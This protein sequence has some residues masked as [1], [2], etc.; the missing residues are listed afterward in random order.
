[1]AF[2]I[3]TYTDAGLELLSKL[4]ATAPL[5]IDRVIPLKQSTTEYNFRRNPIS[6]FDDIA[7]NDVIATVVS[8]GGD[9][10]SDTKGRIVVNL[11]TSSSTTTTKSIY[12]LVVVAHTSVA[13]SNSAAAT[14]FA[15]GTNANDP[16]DK[17]EIPYNANIT[18][19]V[20]VAI[21]FSCSHSTQI[22]VGDTTPDYL[23]ADEVSRFVTTHAMS[24]ATQGDNQIIYGEKRYRNTLMLDGSAG[25]KLEFWYDSDPC[26]N[27]SQSNEWGLVFDVNHSEFDP[28]DDN[29]IYEFK[30]AGREICSLGFKDGTGSLSGL[31]F[32]D[33]NY[34]ACDS[35]EAAG[36]DHKITLDNDLL[37]GDATVSLGNAVDKF[38]GVSAGKVLTNILSSADADVITAVNS[39]IPSIWGTQNLGDLNN[40]WDEVHANNYYEGNAQV[41]LIKR[42][43]IN[44]T[45]VN[46]PLG[47]IIMIIAPSGSEN[48]SAGQ[49]FTVAANTL[50][51][52]SYNTSSGGITT[53]NSKTISAGTYQYLS[54]STNGCPALVIRIA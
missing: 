38:A 35:I 41:P 32:I 23:L 39:L 25:G 3:N 10:N 1:M 12:G 20:N 5:I 40:R 34:L 33:T 53:D 36:S 27:I 19:G 43:S 7:E 48:K 52:A 42:L 11:K 31:N 21:T 14:F 16:N 29:K 15:C 45:V 37:P 26:V 54:G 6:W 17:L 46:V 51:P 18:V 4:S 49:T 47:G 9:P 2:F 24:G 13:G 28:D 8:A 44:N 30:G 50:H 22:I